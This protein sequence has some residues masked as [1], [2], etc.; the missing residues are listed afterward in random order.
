MLESFVEILLKKSQYHFDPISVAQF[1][2]SKTCYTV[3]PSYRINSL[4]AK[5]HNI[6]SYRQVT[7]PKNEN[8]GT[9]TVRQKGNV[10]FSMV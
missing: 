8:Y 6:Q 3:E 10:R 7:K 5:L 9:C 4:E 2:I 1:R